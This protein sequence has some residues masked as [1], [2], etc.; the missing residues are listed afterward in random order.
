MSISGSEAPKVT[1]SAGR[2]DKLRKTNQCR[3]DKC[4]KCQTLLAAGMPALNTKLS[5]VGGCAGAWVVVDCGLLCQ[6]DMLLLLLACF[7]IAS[8]FV[9]AGNVRH[10]KNYKKVQTKTTTKIPRHQW[11]LHDANERV[12]ALRR[13][14]WSC[15]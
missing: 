11:M 15:L 7:H 13:I 10:K 12:T 9:A 14:L 6:K 2:A 1:E 8:M 4:L 5:D 3:C